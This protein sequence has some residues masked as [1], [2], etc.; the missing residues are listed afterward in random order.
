ME[1]IPQNKMGSHHVPSLLIK[2]SLPMML[3]MFV[4][5]LYNIVDS[6]FVSMLSERALTSVT[7]AFPFQMLL[8][9]VSVGTAVGSCSLISRRLG[10]GLQHEADSAASNGMFLAV[11][12][13]IAFGILGL[14]LSRPAIA[15]FTDDIPMLNDSV[16]YLTICSS[17][18]IFSMIQIMCEKTLQGT[19]NMMHP[20]IIQLVGA[21][22]NIVLD[23]I[24][25][26]GLLGFPAMGVAGAAV[27]TVAGQAVG[28]VLGIILLKRSKHIS[29]KLFKVHRVDGRKRISLFKP[30]STTIRETY[31]VGLPAIVMQ[32]VGSVT[33]LGLNAILI[34]FSE[35]AVT[36]LGLYFKLQSF[37]F[38]PVFGLNSGSMPIMAYNYGAKNRPRLMQALKYGCIYAIIVMLIGV[39]LFQLIP[40]QLL[41]LFNAQDSLMEMGIRAFR[42][43]SLCFPFAA[44]SIMFGTMFQALGKGIYSLIVTIA[45]QLI[46]ILPM[47]YILAKAT[48]DVNAVWYAYPIAEVVSLGLSTALL[49]NIY[50]KHIKHF[51]DELV[52]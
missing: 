25:I 36:V 35:T 50:N 19:G 41:S 12:S 48:N 4:M 18:S 20:M 39:A 51:G 21:V 34:S 37:V 22:I 17:L 46:V 10:Q 40:S 24:M 47:A 16:T 11:L 27:A 49:F 30:N 8:V 3:S 28:M 2:M 38:M 1:S 52:K 6:V 7:L 45:R 42:T 5:A 15:M 29:V 9:G 23:P 31:K 14:T 33:N 13:G 44:L 43:I 26:F 32:T